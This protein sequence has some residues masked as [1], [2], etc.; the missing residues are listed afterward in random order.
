MATRSYPLRRAQKIHSPLQLWLGMGV[1]VFLTAFA[2]YMFATMPRATSV[3]SRSGNSVEFALNDLSGEQVKLSDFRGQPVLVN[4]WATWCPP[5][6]AE[7]PDLIAFQ[8]RH[9]AEGL[10]F[11]AIN[12]ED[13]PA[14]A[15][16]F[17]RANQMNVPVLLDSEGSV[18]R[19]MGTGGLPSTFL[20]DR[21]G[22]LI[23]QWTGQISPGVLEQRVV[24]FLKQ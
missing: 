14:L 2:V 21:S 9:Q 13:D 20:F 3:V 7:M 19:A 24:P 11:L 1:G 15:R 8:A 5:C 12:T 4:F 10:Q 22:Q 6:R 16:E 23:F 18:L 17:V